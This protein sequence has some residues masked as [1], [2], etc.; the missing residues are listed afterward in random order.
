MGLNSD[1]VA[2]GISHFGRASDYLYILSKNDST[3]STATKF[4]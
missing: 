3:L 1:F 4:Y 2:F